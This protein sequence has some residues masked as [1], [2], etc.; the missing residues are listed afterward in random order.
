V[1]S[2]LR[3]RNHILLD[4]IDTWPQSLRDLLNSERDLIRS[5]LQEEKRIHDL[6]EGDVL[7]R[8]RP[9]KNPHLLRWNSIVETI[10]QLIRDYS[11]I[12]FH[13][14]RLT[15]TEIQGIRAN[16]LRPLS[17]AFTQQRIERL[18]Q[19]GRISPAA[20]QALIERNESSASNR[21]G[22]VCFFHC[23]STLRDASGL[24]RL[25]RSWGGEAVYYHHEEDSPARE[26]LRRIGTPCIVVGSLRRCD[27]SPIRSLEERIIR[28]W[29]SQND[30]GAYSQD[31]DTLVRG[32][33]VPV[34]DVISRDSLLFEELTHYSE[35]S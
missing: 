15:E 33:S 10:R 5:Y 14:T 23:L 25:F 11:I 13:C 22:H 31:C 30:P 16:G 19:E 12:G 27:I 29:Q 18:V 2:P 3:Y 24:Y 7:I 20:A 28:V 34:L 26:E 4:G 8:L 6:V 35:W 9:P 21:A 17:P 32:R 1:S